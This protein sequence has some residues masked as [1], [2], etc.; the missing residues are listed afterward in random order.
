MGYFWN[1]KRHS[2]EY[3]TCCYLRCFRSR[4]SY[5]TCRIHTKPNGPK[6]NARRFAALETNGLCASLSLSLALSRARRRRLSFHLPPS[7]IH[8]RAPVPVP[9]LA[10]SG[11]GFLTLLPAGHD[12]PGGCGGRDKQPWPAGKQACPHQLPATI[13]ACDYVYSSVRTIICTTAECG[14]FADASVVAS[15]SSYDPPCTAQHSTAQHTVEHKTRRDET[16]QLS[17]STNIGL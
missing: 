5:P 3:S 6:N 9:S 10:P 4:F 17:S 14:T 15:D 12:R 7:L 13:A 8:L 11:S 2:A 16:T 1:E